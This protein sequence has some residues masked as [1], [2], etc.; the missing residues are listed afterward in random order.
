MDSAFLE[1]LAQARPDPGGGAAAAH[2]GAL[3][4]ALLAKVVQLE[5]RRPGPSRKPGF[6]WRDL[7]ARVS[8]GR[9]ALLP[10]VD[11]LRPRKLIR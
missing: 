9:A 8:G 11:C 5:Q 6:S 3:G 4:L 1:A 2:S 10:R 7:L